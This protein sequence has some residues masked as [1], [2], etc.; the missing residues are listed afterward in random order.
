M[1]NPTSRTFEQ[2]SGAGQ[3]HGH[4]DVDFQIARIRELLSNA[5]V[6]RSFIAAHRERTRTWALITSDEDA[7][8]AR[9]V[10]LVEGNLVAIDHGP[11]E[12][13]AQRVLLSEVEGSVTELYTSKR[14]VTA[15]AEL[16]DSLCA[17]GPSNS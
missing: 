5:P 14:F 4:L 13:I 2:R 6:L 15:Q 17:D 12:V 3:A 10:F 11:V 16:F 8:R 9:S 7:G 1:S